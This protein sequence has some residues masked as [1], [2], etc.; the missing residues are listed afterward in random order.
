M[1]SES[2]ALI[3]V[4]TQ[5]EPNDTIL[6]LPRR[7]TLTVMY[8]GPGLSMLQLANYGGRAFQSIANY[9]FKGPENPK[10]WIVNYFGDDG[11]RQTALDNLHHHNRK[12]PSSPV[13]QKQHKALREHCHKLLKYA[14][15]QSHTVDTQLVTFKMLVAIIPRYPGLRVLF[16]DHK[17]FRDASLSHPEHL[18]KR[19]QDCGREWTFYRDFVVFCISEGPLT[20]LVEGRLPSEL[21]RLELMDG[22]LNKVPAESLLAYWPEFDPPRLCAIRYLAGI[23]ELRSFWL[24]G[25]DNPTRLYDILSEI[26]E[27]TLQLIQDTEIDVA[28]ENYSLIPWLSAA[29][30]A[31]DVLACTA[32]DGLLL[33]DSLNCLPCCPP[34]LP[35]I[36]SILTRD[37]MQKRFPKAFAP[38]FLVHSI[39]ERSPRPD[40]DAE[41]EAEINRI[42][43]PHSEAENP[44]SSDSPDSVANALDDASAPASPTPSILQ[45]SPPQDD[46]E[47]N[48][49]PSPPAAAPV[50]QDHRSPSQTSLTR[51][52]SNVAPS[53]SPTVLLA[54]E[55]MSVTVTTPDH[56]LQAEEEQ[57]DEVL[58]APRD[59][60]E[61]DRPNSRISSSSVTS[62]ASTRADSILESFPFVPPSPIFDRPVRSPPVSPLRQQSFGS[63]ASTPRHAEFD[64]ILLE[65]SDDILIE[66]DDDEILVERNQYETIRPRETAAPPK[67]DEELP[68]A[69]DWTSEKPLGEIQ[70][71]FR[72]LMKREEEEQRAESIR[73][74]TSAVSRDTGPPGIRGPP[75]ASQS[76]QAS[77]A[78]GSIALAS[79]TPQNAASNTESTVSKNQNAASNTEKVF[80][81]SLSAPLDV[82]L[83]RIARYEASLLSHDRRDSSAGHREDDVVLVEDDDDEI[84][85]ARG[86][87][88]AVGGFPEEEGGYTSRL[89][90]SHA[91]K[92]DRSPPV[93]SP[94]ATIRAGMSNGPTSPRGA[95]P[96]PDEEGGYTPRS[97]YSGLPPFIPPPLY[98]GTS[99]PEPRAATASVQ[100][101][102]I[103]PDDVQGGYTP[104]SPYS[105]LPPF[106]PPPRGVPPVPDEEEG[107]TLRSPYSALPPGPP[108]VPD[109]EEGLYTPRSPHSALPPIIPPPRPVLDEEGLYPP[110][111][112]YSAL[113]PIIPPPLY[114]KGTSRP[115]P[116]A[117]T[118]SVQHTHIAP[119]DVQYYTDPPTMQAYFNSP[120]P[121]APIPPTPHS[122]T[123]V[124][125]TGSPYPY[126]FNHVRRSSAYPYASR[127]HPSDDPNHRSTIQEQ[128]ARQWQIYAQNQ[129]ALAGE[130]ITDDADHPAMQ[131][132][133]NSPQPDAPIPPTPHS[134]TPVPP[135]GSP[136][137]YPFNHVRRSSAYP[138]A[139]RAHPSD[140]PNHR[141]TIQEQLARQWQIYAQNQSALAG[142]SDN[143]YFPRPRAPGPPSRTPSPP[144]SI[145]G[146]DNERE[147]YPPFSP[148]APVGSLYPYPFNRIRRKSGY[149][150]ASRAYPSDDP[151]HPSAIQEQLARQWQVYAQNQSV[152]ADGHVSDRTFTPSPESPHLPDIEPRPIT[153]FGDFVD[154][155]VAAESHTV[156]E[157]INDSTGDLGF[158]PA[159]F[160]EVLKPSRGDAR[161]TQQD[162]RRT[163][164][165]REQSQRASTPPALARLL[166]MNQDVIAGRNALTPV[167]NRDDAMREWERRQAGKPSAAQWY[168]QLEYLQQQAEMAAVA[169]TTN[170]A[171]KKVPRTSADDDA[172]HY[173]APVARR[174]NTGP[175]LNA[176]ATASNLPPTRTT[177]SAAAYA[178]IH[179]RRPDIPPGLTVPIAAAAT[180]PAA[181]Q[182]KP[183]APF[184]P[185]DG[186]WRASVISKAVTADANP[187][188]LREILT[189]PNRFLFLVQRNEVVNTREANPNT[190]RDPRENPRRPPS[191]AIILMEGPYMEAAYPVL[192][193]E[194]DVRERTHP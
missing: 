163:V 149:P 181:I 103:A 16:Y 157:H 33:L 133:F 107:Y 28:H 83:E 136:Y 143:P 165:Q 23:L 150:Y 50:D 173:L 95:S 79:T 4:E 154:R 142:V 134:Q 32:L 7:N 170:W 24:Q 146:A 151:N 72:R 20:V 49:A 171:R 188:T 120:R 51:P 39:L 148:I 183:A 185:Y 182:R 85:I 61:D 144:S 34:Q 105:A 63:V 179:T 108:L 158:D 9:C 84:L 184:Q 194:E 167:L 140:D 191:A 65:D 164:G 93:T 87:Y 68:A 86:Q 190:P 5:P 56:S 102:H 138:Y 70:Q 41:T 109:E 126:P 71:V 35:T 117:A 81:R 52:T 54:G 44:F 97:P 78:S 48:R 74:E 166:R 128:L 116:R 193:P 11:E 91:E 59:H 139:S 168:P 104:R 101:T 192:G 159:I 90:P 45:H 47:I 92:P 121:D 114:K 15:P 110:R 123:P 67:K 131:T 13:I 57:E 89:P 30:H 64:D 77:T 112:P 10:S 46:E 14:R 12:H 186:D 125:P 26:C 147:E 2:T 137:P 118:A 27:T 43:S 174:K 187:D 66:D 162:H 73:T 122:Q 130:N 75:E 82:H 100:H 115:E 106:I 58:A 132:Y 177:H 113:P 25:K 55:A 22:S 62:A 152:L 29:C 31:L 96:V 178:R 88:A 98:K 176:R 21:G 53:D 94:N 145:S 155:T 69:S 189:E 40:Q 3:C 169:G 160:A 19:D 6:P 80:D 8:S 172:S 135:T 129:S 141:S 175:P 124:P 76:P 153:P 18:W 161:G 111:S 42:P 127:A 37:H 60:Y 1:A 38:A 17:D 180:Q 119:D 36:V 156:N 99:R